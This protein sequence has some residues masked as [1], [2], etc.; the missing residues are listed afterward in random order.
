MASGG[1]SLGVVARTWAPSP[2]KVLF[3]IYLCAKGI[4]AHGEGELR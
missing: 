3:R 2:D 4:Q 1:L